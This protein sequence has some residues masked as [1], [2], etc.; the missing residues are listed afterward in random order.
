[1]STLETKESLPVTFSPLLQRYSLEEFWTLPEP[2]GRAHYDLI[3]G[4]LFMV[5]PPGP[6]HGDIDS[7][8]KAKLILF[9]AAHG[10]PGS[11]YHPR[12]AIL[13]DDTYVEPDMMYVSHDLRAGMGPRRTSADIVFEYMSASTAN[14]DRTTKAD[15]YL[16]LGVRELWLIDPETNTIEVRNSSSKDKLLIWERQLYSAGQCASS[17]VLDGWQVSVDELFAGLLSKPQ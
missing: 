14:Y 16:A 4:Y 10:Q 5:P 13:V 8:L 9:L 17:R 11:V 12:E 1:M 3:G 2:E 7:R 6:P 15:T